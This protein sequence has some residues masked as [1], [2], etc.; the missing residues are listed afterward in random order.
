[1]EVIQ[2]VALRGTENDPVTEAMPLTFPDSAHFPA[3]VKSI[4][5]PDRVNTDVS[6]GVP[7]SSKVDLQKRVIG[8]QRCRQDERR[9]HVLLKTED[10][11]GKSFCG[12][13][14]LRNGWILTAA[15]CWESGRTVDAFLG[16]HMGNNAPVRIPLGFFKKPKVYKVGFL[17]NKKK[18]DLML[19]KLPDTATIPAGVTTIDLPDCSNQPKINDEVQIAGQGSTFG[20]FFTKRQPGHTPVLQCG[21]INKINCPQ[22]IFSINSYIYQYLFCGKTPGVDICSCSVCLSQGDSGGGVE[23]N[24]RIY[25]VQVLVG[26]FPCRKPA[27]FMDLCHPDY[28]SW[29][30]KTIG[31]PP[32]PGF[33]V[34]IER[35]GKKLTHPEPQTESGECVPP[36]DETDRSSFSPSV[37]IE[38]DVFLTLAGWGQSTARMASSNTV[39]KPR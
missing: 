17:F 14:L 39:F 29:I 9:Y 5:L 25:G 13:S 30:E 10:S 38:Q 7:T 35:S 22:Q 24:G 36:G 18:H 3:G 12:G 6:G 26:K 8:G 16:F 20:S 32:N 15:H 33:D 2:T 11:K 4:D 28:L 37:S 1:M 27:L 34:Q 23:Y 19:L 31:P 21:N